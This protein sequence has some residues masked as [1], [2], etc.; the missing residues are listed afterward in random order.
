MDFF[1]IGLAT[2]VITLAT[3]ASYYYR[4]V[5]SATFTINNIRFTK[6]SDGGLSTIVRGAIYNDDD[7]L[8]CQG[9]IN[10]GTIAGFRSIP[11]VVESGQ[12]LII[13]AGQAYW[14]AIA[15]SQNNGNWVGSNTGLQSTAWFYLGTNNYSTT[16]FPAT[17]N[18]VGIA[19]TKLRPAATFYA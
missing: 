8:K 4:F 2:Q 9:A 3:T 15:V 12:D 17:R 5:A 6:E 11:M 1:P 10:S 16:P 19:N 7:S 14:F 18:V 13:T